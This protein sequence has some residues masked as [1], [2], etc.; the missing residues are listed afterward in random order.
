MYTSPWKQYRYHRRRRERRDLSVR[1]LAG[2]FHRSRK[3]RRRRARFL[4]RGSRARCLAEE[5]RACRGWL[6]ICGAVLFLVRLRSL[7]ESSVTHETVRF[8]KRTL[9]MSDNCRAK[10]TTLQ[11]QTRPPRKA[12]ATTTIA[13]CR[14]EALTGQASVTIKR[15]LA[16]SALQQ[17]TCCPPLGN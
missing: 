10:V 1:K 5:D 8:R 11:S 13:T 17:S 2:E 7:F 6:G 4:R 3:C 14:L 15:A 16:S 12:A 9:Q